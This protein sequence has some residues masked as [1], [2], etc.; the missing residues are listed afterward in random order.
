MAE[1]GGQIRADE[2]VRAAMAASGADSAR[3]LARKLGLSGYDSPKRVERWLRGENSPGFDAT[4]ALLQL[5]GLLNENRLAKA[6]AA[7][8]D[9]QS[10]AAATRSRRRR[11]PREE[12]G[13]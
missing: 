2:L 3:A 13:T 5:A 12:T 8:E 9:A 7:A 4:I 1:L 10:Q 6:R 11:S